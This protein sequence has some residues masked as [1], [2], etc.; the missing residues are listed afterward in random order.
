MEFRLLGP[1]E[2]LERGAVVPLGGPR[3]RALL[4]LL[5][6][7]ANKVV[8][9]ERLIDGLWGEEPPPAAANSLQV[10]VHGLRKALGADRIE[11]RG[12]GYVLRVSPV[13]LDLERFE[14]LVERARKESPGAA[15]TTLEEALALW[16]GEPLAD[17]ADASAALTGLE[18]ARIAALE[19]RIDA[20]LALG[21]HAE[22][23]GE[24]EGL[25][26]EHPFR[27]RLRGQLM[28]ALYRSGR[29][30][31]ALAAYQGAREALVEH[32]GVE[33]GEE[34]R[35]LER[36]ILRQ[37]ASLAAPRR[38]RQSKLPAPASSL[39]GRGL[40]RAAVTALLGRDDVRLLTLTGPGGTGKTRLALEAAAELAPGFVD[41]AAFVDLAP[42]D[43]PAL[44]P[45]TVARALD[46]VESEVATVE[47]LKQALRPRAM[48]LVLDNFERVDDAAPL[49]SELLSAAP[50]LKVL[51]TSRVVLRLSGEHE[52]PVPPLRIPDR[53]L[54][55]DLEG[56]GRNE[57]VALFVARAR[58]VQH[59]FRLSRENAEAVA[60]I[61]VDLDGLPLAIELAAARVTLH[62]PALL[63]ER[64]EQRLEVLTGGPRDVPERHQ[65]LR[66]TIDWSYELLDPGERELFARLAVFA[67]GC[68]TDAV[69]SVCEAP[70]ETLETLL[71]H[72][73]LQRET[74]RGGEPR[75]RMLETV[76]AYA[77]ERLEESGEAERLRERHAAYFLELAET[78]G[79]AL[80]APVQGPE[81]GGR[82][83]RLEAEHDNLRAALAWAER[84]DPEVG[85]RIAAALCDFWAD[86]SYLREALSSL[87][88]ALAGAG[89]APAPLRAKALHGACYVAFLQGEY[90][91]GDELGEASLAL[92]R[93]LGDR[94]GE[95]RTLHIR[96]WAAAHR[97]DVE[98]A[99][100]LA[101]DSLALARELGHTRGVIVSLNGL[102]NAAAAAGDRKRA[103]ALYEEGLELAREHGDRV[104]QA[105]ILGAWGGL[106]AEQGDDETAGRML[107]ESLVLCHQDGHTRGV[108]GCLHN[109]AMLAQRNGRQDTAVALSAAAAGV[110][111]ALGGSLPPVS[112]AAAEE[113]VA[114]ARA[115]LG[116]EQFAAAWTHGRALSLHEAVDLG[117]AAATP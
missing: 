100:R 8:S 108:G 110:L 95:G 33:P 57:A 96:G 36:A 117:R 1:L 61:C 6:L 5:L 107:A 111:D 43:E 18:E 97:G 103:V 59:D 9:R 47:R 60:A 92:Y 21:R 89:S 10:A 15:A 17:L 90:E 41:G 79:A 91:R 68:S 39:V 94:E 46:V 65:T 69:E 19:Q 116:E 51:V 31:D 37:D 4:T 66:A 27:E 104:G 109:I 74:A 106:A 113:V 2:V 40:E 52:Y 23:A 26:A 13:E 20:D 83:D 16:R 102:A 81:R 67:G 85:L 77:R 75:L 38:E 24:L 48:L 82:L 35:G 34:L 22:L 70:L 88:R 64:L 58:A 29:Q 86:R 50:D 101:G 93:Q 78:L 45:A 12:P 114:A 84:H 80:W 3:Q 25:I 44:V 105:G 11:T 56:L 62:P 98:Q 7:S 49:V 115:A 112:R 76:R 42:L 55:R 71:A 73:L 32:L 63:R 54:V 28:L 30:A 87:E 99:A 72:S 14:R 53:A